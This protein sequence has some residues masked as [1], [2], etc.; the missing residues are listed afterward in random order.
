LPNPYGDAFLEAKVVDILPKEIKV[1][2]RQKE[3]ELHPYT[4][5]DF[6]VSY[7]DCQKLTYGANDVSDMVDL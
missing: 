7:E 3:D 5:K 2:L 1:V 6:T 4:L